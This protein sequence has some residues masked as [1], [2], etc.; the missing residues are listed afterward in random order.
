MTH[1]MVCVDASEFSSVAFETALRI[2]K[3]DS[4]VLFIVNC[5]EEI[6]ATHLAALH[7]VREAQEQL[8]TQSSALLHKYG[9]RARAAGFK[10][11]HLIRGI[12]THEGEFIV[13]C[14][15]K[16]QIDMVFMG[17][18]GMG[19]IQR[20]FVG[21]TSKYVLEHC[22]CNVFIVKTPLPAA[23]VHVDKRA[24]I[25]AEEEERARQ[26]R[27]KGAEKHLEAFR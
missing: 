4:A 5:V 17:R 14:A 15:E 3:P 21:S 7:L 22:P 26:I 1:Y 12:S 16:K 8:K 2:A 23:E 10:N 24:V 9:D 25:K 20:F 18:R 13:H 19:S 6:R 11:I 27:E